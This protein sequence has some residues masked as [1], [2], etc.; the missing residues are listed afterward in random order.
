MLHAEDSVNIA[1]IIN[2]ETE[3]LIISLYT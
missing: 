3:N 1:K 2:V